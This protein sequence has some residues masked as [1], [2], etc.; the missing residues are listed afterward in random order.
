MPYAI[1][2][3]GEYLKWVWNNGVRN[4]GQAVPDFMNWSNDIAKAKL[5]KTK[6]TPAKLVALHPGMEVVEITVSTVIVPHVVEMRL[7]TT[8]KQ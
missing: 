2:K 1:T 7:L 4:D 5:W 8:P 6:S 3:N